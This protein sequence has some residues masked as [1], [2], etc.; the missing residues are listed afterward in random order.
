VVQEDRYDA[1][2][3]AAG[4]LFL[5][6]SANKKRP[7]SH[8]DDSPNQLKPYLLVVQLKPLYSVYLIGFYLIGLI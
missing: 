4:S 8:C 3:L 5:F 7:P 1:C 6:D 2:T